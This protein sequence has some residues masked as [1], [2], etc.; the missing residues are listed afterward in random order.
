MR[1]AVLSDIHSNLAAFEAVQAAIDAEEPDC[2]VVAGDAI[3]RGPQPRPCLERL[4]ALLDQEEWRV[5]KGNHED[6]VLMMFE[7]N[8]SLAPWEIDVLAHTKWT[9]N[10]VRDLL[11]RVAQWPDQ[12]SLYGPDGSEVR[13][14]H[15]SMRGNRCGLYADMEEPLLMELTSPSPAVLVAGHTHIPFVRQIE[16]SL[17]VNA[18]A[19]GLPFDGDPNPSYAILDWRSGEWSARIERVRYDRDATEQA[20]RDSGYLQDGG[21]MTRL[22]LHELRTARP[23]IGVWHRR[24]E[25]RVAAGELTVEESV[26][27]LL[28]ELSAAPV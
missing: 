8:R 7:G 5:I 18:G 23:R 11:P 14:V 13:F 3:N 24:Y 26:R 22:I 2:V 4:L 16:N 17:I 15:A 9:V 10:H 20:M 6:Y 1:I 28:D 19:S 25:A 27:H 12:L 21:P